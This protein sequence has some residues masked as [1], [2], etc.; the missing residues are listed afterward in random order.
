MVS[1]LMRFRSS[2]IASK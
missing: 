1:R 2:R